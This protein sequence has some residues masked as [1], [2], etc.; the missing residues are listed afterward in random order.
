MIKTA[1]VEELLDKAKKCKERLL[2]KLKG[3]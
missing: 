1:N 3:S 2:E